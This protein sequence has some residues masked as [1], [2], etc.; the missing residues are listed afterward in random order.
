[1]KTPTTKR[2]LV[3]VAA[4]TCIVTAVRAGA[5][6]RDD[7]KGVRPCFDDA[8]T[9]DP[10]PLAVGDTLYVYTGQDADDADGFKMPGWRLYSTKDMKTWK[11]H[12]IVA[13]PDG[14]FTWGGK[15]T[16]WASQCVGRNG[17]YYFYTTCIDKRKGWC[18]SIGVLVADRPEGPFK[19]PIGEPLIQHCQGDI[20]P[21]VF[22]DDDGQ[23]WLYWGNPLLHTAKLN[24]DMISIDKSYGDNG[25]KVASERLKDYQEGPWVWKRD[26]KY[27]MA[28][29]STC[30]PE[31][32]GYSMSTSP[33]GPWEYKGHI[34]DHDIRSSGNHPGLVA[35]NGKW[36]CFGF[37]YQ[38][39]HRLNPGEKHRERRSVCFTEMT[40]NPDG[41]IRQLPWWADIQ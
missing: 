27:Y 37:G 3:A 23:A 16:A 6:D 31:G 4:A 12:G 7:Q 26:G 35:F 40:Y 1:M 25:I 28:Y 19:D 39:Y 17:K 34:M 18:M 30:C 24:A 2:M 9:A 21:T 20:D 33:E 22:V 10:A 8:F 13:S 15:N 14:N 11:S 36:Y 5:A 38:R 41:T 32:I 29:A